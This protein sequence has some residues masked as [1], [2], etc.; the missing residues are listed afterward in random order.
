MYPCAS[1]SHPPADSK[2]TDPS[3]WGTA[4]AICVGQSGSVDGPI[5]AQPAS[6]RT[7][8][9]RPSRTRGSW[10]GDTRDNL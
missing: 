7:M 3:P 10:N 4:R 1:G 8:S 9:A 5:P 6:S 2:R